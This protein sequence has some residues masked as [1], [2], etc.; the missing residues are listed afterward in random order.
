MEPRGEGMWEK[1]EGFTWYPRP[2]P[3]QP[4]IKVK[5]KKLVCVHGNKSPKWCDGGR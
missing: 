2:T 4:R 3:T 1:K 5:K